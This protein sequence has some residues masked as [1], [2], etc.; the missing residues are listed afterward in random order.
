[1]EKVIHTIEPVF[2]S[3]S[4]ILMLGSIPSPK[5]REQ[6]FYYGHPQNRFWRVMAAVFNVPDPKTIVERKTMLL[7]HNIALWDVLQSCYIR[8]AADSSIKNPIANDFSRI[9]NSA[10]IQAVFTTGKI[11]HRLYRTLTGNESILLPS[12]S[13][14]NCAISFDELCKQYSVI[15]DYI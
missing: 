1:M 13:P 9:F 3:Q 12:T 7:K 5:S 4:K 6:Q 2:S 8:G 14:A 10:S 15:L 11:A